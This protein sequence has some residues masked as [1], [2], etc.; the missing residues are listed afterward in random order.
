MSRG[1]V[2][3]NDCSKQRAAKTQ[4]ACKKS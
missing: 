3:Y 1:T 2:T 4:M